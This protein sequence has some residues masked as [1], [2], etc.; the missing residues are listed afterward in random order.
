MKKGH[1]RSYTHEHPSGDVTPK[2][3]SSGF[4]GTTCA[5]LMGIMTTPALATERHSDIAAAARARNF[6]FD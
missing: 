3:Q 4:L 2:K 6:M 1:D 5:C